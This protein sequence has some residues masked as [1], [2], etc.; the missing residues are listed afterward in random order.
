MFS[1]FQQTWWTDP[2]TAGP[3]PGGRRTGV[4]RGPSSPGRNGVRSHL[5]RRTSYN[6]SPCH[7]LSNVTSKLFWWNERSLYQLT[8]RNRSCFTT[9]AQS[10]NFWPG[11]L[12]W[13]LQHIVT[14][15]MTKPS[16]FRQIM[17]VSQS[18]GMQQ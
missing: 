2:H 14:A 15:K 4:N 1:I 7:K 11:T 13:T 17:T 9:N 16:L 5:P 12:F 3:I 10:G 18:L 8:W 6:S